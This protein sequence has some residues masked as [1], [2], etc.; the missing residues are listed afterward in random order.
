MS[1]GG[2]TVSHALRGLRLQLE[3]Y[4]A[5]ELPQWEQFVGHTKILRPEPGEVIITAGEHHPY[6]YYVQSGLLKAKM[7]VE[8]G[9]RSATVF[10]SEEG[11]IMASMPALAME[12]VRR[13]ATRD[14]HPRSRTIL[15]AIEAQSIHTVTA[16]EHSLLVQANFR[17]IDQLASKHVAWARLIANLAVMHATTLQ[18]DVAWLRSTPETRYRQLLVDHPGLVH[19]V[20]QRDLASFLNI[21]DVAL[22]RIVKRVRDADTSAHTDTPVAH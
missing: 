14:I 10:F 17:I 1:T 5:A 4:A 13:A 11:D 16:L 20:T 15:A 9:R 21:T 22:S 7:Q 6:V 19:R 12:G 2:A 18:T 3:A 8:S